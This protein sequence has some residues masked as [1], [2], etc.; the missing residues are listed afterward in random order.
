MNKN[1]KKPGLVAA[2]STAAPDSLDAEEAPA[3]I[4]A[5]GGVGGEKRR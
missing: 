2:G 4:H 5:L 3:G 1:G